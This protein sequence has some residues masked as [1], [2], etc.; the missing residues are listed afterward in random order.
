MTSHLNS[1]HL[2]AGVKSVELPHFITCSKCSKV[3]IILHGAVFLQSE[4][5]VLNRSGNVL[6]MKKQEDGPSAGQDIALG[7]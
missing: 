5:S 1:L 7:S 2:L 6:T 4:D 3:E